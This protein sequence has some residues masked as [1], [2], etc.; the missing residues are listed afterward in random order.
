VL[1]PITCCQLRAQ[2]ALRR[3]WGSMT[4]S[5]AA[6]LSACLRPERIC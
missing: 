5:A 6:V 2:H 4:F 3:H 1:A